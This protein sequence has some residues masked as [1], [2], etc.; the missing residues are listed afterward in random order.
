VNVALDVR[1]VLV[2]ATLDPSFD[3]VLDP[4]TFTAVK[5]VLAV[6]TRTTGGAITAGQPRKLVVTGTR[7]G[8][9]VGASAVL[10]DLTA[11][12]PVAKTWLQ[13]YAWGQASGGGTA[14]RVA[15]GDTRGNL[16]L[17]PVGP[18]GAITI[19]N[20]RRGVQLRVDVHGY[21]N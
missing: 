7:T 12:A 14:L 19:A 13:T 1:A 5:P 3:P 16:V 2:D 9:P 20:A 8:V 17:V 11:I 21:L 18:G 15:K 4:G 6:D 10:V